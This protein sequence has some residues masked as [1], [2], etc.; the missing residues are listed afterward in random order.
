MPTRHPPIDL[1]EDIAAPD[2]WDLLVSAEAKTNPRVCT[3]VGRL[4]LVPTARRVGGPGAS[5]LMAPFVH[6]STERP[7]RFHDGTYGAWYAANRFQTAVAETA[8]HMAAFYRSTAQTPGWLVQ[9]RELIARVDH[10]FHDLRAAPA[11][12]SALDPNDYAPSQALAWRLRSDHRSDGIVYPAV[13]D[14]QGEALAAFWPDVVRPPVTPGRH[15]GY[16]FDGHLIDYVRDASSGEL[17]RL[18][19]CA[20]AP[21]APS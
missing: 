8:H 4:D 13:R 9:V 14:G 15:L 18:H 1:F 3:S 10:R 21:L 6:V 5:Y 16:H 7:G 2:D 19:G 17:W 12:E 11:F 20:P